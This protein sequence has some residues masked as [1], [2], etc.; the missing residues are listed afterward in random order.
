MLLL[1]AAPSATTSSVAAQARVL[2][3]LQEL[4]SLEPSTRVVGLAHAAQTRDAIFVDPMLASL[5][6]AE[7]T[8]RAGAARALGD[9]GLPRTGEDLELILRGLGRTCD[10][11][12][13]LVAEAAIVALSRFPFPFVRQRLEVIAKTSTSER[14]RVAARQRIAEFAGPEARQRLLAWTEV[15]AG[16]A[17]RLDREPSSD[18]RFGRSAADPLTNVSRFVSRHPDRA[19][20]LAKLPRT[21]AFLPFY[22]LGL[23]DAK[24][25]VR[26]AAVTALTEADFDGARSHLLAALEDPDV[27]VRRAAAVAAADPALARSAAIRLGSEEDGEARARLVVALERGGPEVLEGVLLWLPAAEGPFAA[28][29]LRVLAGREEPAVDEA[30]V[31]IASRDA[32]RAGVEAAERLRSLPDERVV[33]AL[34]A[35]LSRVTEPIVRK[36]LISLFEGREGAV[37]EDGFLKEVEAGRADPPLIARVDRIPEGLAL[38]RLFAALESA[39]PSVRAAALAALASRRGPEVAD[40]LGRSAR[41]DPAAA[42]PFASLLAQ[43]PEDAKRALLAL[44]VDPAQASRHERIMRRL[45]LDP[46]IAGLVAGA[47]G[48]NPDLSP[49]AL[50]VLAPLTATST[51]LAAYG[52]IS[53]LAIAP[54]ELRVAAINALADKG[55]RE[56]IPRLEPSARDEVTEVK[57]AARAAL[58]DIDPDRY[59]AWDPYGRVPLVLEGAALGASALLIAADVSNANLSPIFTGIA[60]A[61]LGGATPFLLT[62][63]EDL[64]L[65]QAG[66]FG[67]A[68]LWGTALGWGVGGAVGFDDRATGGATLVGQALGATAGAIFLRDSEWGL[69]ELALSNALSLEAALLGGTISLL[70]DGDFP[71]HH[72][73]VAGALVSIPAMA[74]ARTL[75]LKDDVE[76]TI[77]SAGLGAFLGAL[78]P[79]AALSESLSTDSALT[80]ALGGQALGVITAVVL[81]DFVSM[82]ARDAGF[83]GLGSLA[84]AA[85]LSGGAMFLDLDERVTFGLGDAGGL[86]GAVALGLLSDRLVLRENDASMIALSTLAGAFAGARFEVHE[87]EGTFDSRAFPGGIL[88]GTGLGFGVGM[89]VSQLVDVS[90]HALWHTVSAGLVVG[91]GGAGAGRLFGLLARD[92]GV[93]T[94]LSALGGIL[95]TAPFAEELDLGARELELMVLHGVTGAALGSLLPSY[96]A[97]PDDANRAFGGSLLGA[98][99]GV[100]SGVLVARDLARS[101]VAPELGGLASGLSLSMGLSLAFELADA[102]TAALVQSGALVGL[103]AGRLI[104]GIDEESRRRGAFSHAALSSLVGAMEGGFVSLGLETLESQTSLGAVLT[105]AGVGS[106]LGMVLGTQL[107]SP[108]DG[109][110]LTETGLYSG[111]S[112]TLGLGLGAVFDDRRVGGVSAAIAGALGYGAG[113]WLSPRTD[114]VSRDVLSM[115]LGALVLGSFGAAGPSASGHYERDRGLGGLLSGASLGALLGSVWAQTVSERDEA[116]VLLTSAAGASL[117]FGLG[118][119]ASRDNQLGYVGLDVLGVSALAASLALSGRTTLDDGDVALIA[120]SSGLGAWFG[121]ALPSAL[122]RTGEERGIVGGMTSGLGAGYLAALAVSQVVDVRPEDVI[123]TTILTSAASLGGLGLLES[124][125]G[126][127]ERG[128]AIALE[129]AGAAGLVGGAL[130]AAQTRY[131]PEDYGLIGLSAGIGGFQGIFLPVS[132]GKESLGSSALFGASLGLTTGMVV[133]QWME[134]D[135]GDAYDILLT[136]LSADA[137]GAATGWLA[138]GRDR[139][140]AIGFEL[141]GLLGMTSAL[142]LAPSLELSAADAGLVATGAGTGALEGAILADLALNAPGAAVL[143]GLGVGTATGLLLSPVTEIDGTDQLESVLD[144]ALLGSIGAG[145]WLSLVEPELGTGGRIL[146]AA[147]AALGLGLGLALSPSTEYSAEDRGLLVELAAL[148]AWHGSTVPVLAGRAEGRREEMRAGGALLG[149]GAFG[150]AGMAMGPLTELTA[151]DLV[152][153]AAIS[154]LGNTLG[155]GLGAS[156]PAAGE[157]ETLALA[158]GFG[159]AGLGLALAFSDELALEGDDAFTLATPAMLGGAWGGFLPVLWRA[160]SD[161][162]IEV[163]IGGGLAFGASAGILAGMALAQAGVDSRGSRSGLYGGI[164]GSLLG[165]GL[166]LMLSEDDRLGVGLLEG[167]GLAGAVAGAYAGLTDDLSAGEVM[168]GLGQMGYLTWHALGVSLLLEGTDRQAAGAVVAAV[169]AG[170]LSGALLVPHLHLDSTDLWMLFAGSVWGGWIGGWGGALVQDAVAT[171]LEGRASTG[172]ALVSTVLGSD[173]GLGLVSLVVGELLD[174]EPTRFAVINLSGLGGMMLGML[175]AGFAQDEPLGFGNVIG[176]L[177][178]LTGGTI[179][180]SFFDF[181]ETPSPYES[182]E[183]VSPRTPSLISIASVVPSLE[184]TPEPNGTSGVKLTLAG[185]FH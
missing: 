90:D 53:E 28:A 108:L 144:G 27:N 146:T 109:A 99:L 129:L 115:G 49:V 104:A 117:G 24:S 105:G 33:P 149:I 38:P 1:W 172:A 55:G 156:I 116:E 142:M 120:A 18:D 100:V 69:G 32:G 14:R 87:E 40:A 70:A 152:E 103:T 162:E 124:F 113:L 95:V 3:A 42:A 31:M 96:T 81:S 168:L 169:G 127:S 29:A 151:G 17:G 180:T 122:G 72:A 159:L 73:I 114:Y 44:L 8:V 10:D 59:P 184:V 51:V 170:A 50:E 131:S 137:I 157:V 2:S 136:Q 36:R 182:P 75:T 35:R 173:V 58:H 171:P 175:V 181:T 177:A 21:S 135:S 60:G 176:S 11:P 126:A 47:A 147:P 77:T 43:R 48:I 65:G 82:D 174:V 89:L 148:G 130:V 30:F 94:G 166:G 13:D 4:A 57:L 20:S 98:S 134:L 68:A 150:L 185:T 64:S 110:D 67:T 138:S 153:V 155:L 102:P 46:E 26:V 22:S 118:R 84:G 83:I 140:A 158:D 52:A 71:F 106:G 101:A 133:S 6:E 39:D 165:G 12:D 92:R 85:L 54:V 183:A 167:L 79:G 88:A 41:R 125:E 91:A 141:A 16:E 37:V 161:T 62:R 107:A 178:G 160:S 25:E 143:L 15:L 128:S 112:G 119:L 111:V 121:G 164:S 86:A 63:K 80:G 78:L 132:W 76:L 56:A 145:I 7:P 93:V 97:S 139:D 9:F 23:G 179:V 74:L 45:P 61:V 5:A 66:F 154:V 19:R 163:T 123:E 34:F